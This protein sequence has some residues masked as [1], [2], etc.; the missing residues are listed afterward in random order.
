M[1]AVESI[2]LIITGVGLG[3]HRR[4]PEFEEF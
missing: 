4:H 2:V 1:C 3:L